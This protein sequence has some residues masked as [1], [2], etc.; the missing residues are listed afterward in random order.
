MELSLSPFGEGP[1]LPQLKLSFDQGR[2]QLGAGAEVLTASPFFTNPPVVTWGHLSPSAVPHLANPLM[3]LS[4]FFV[5]F[6]FTDDTERLH[7][8]WWGFRFVHSVWTN[9][10]YGTSEGCHAV[11]KWRRPANANRTPNRYTF[12]LF[13]HPFPLRLLG[14]SWDKPG[15]LAQVQRPGWQVSLPAF[16]FNFTVEQLLADN[17]GMT[18]IGMTYINVLQNGGQTCRDA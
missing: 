10:L 6:G 14:E 15:G 7:K 2:V 1:K 5:D 8:S 9:C 13:A 11:V 18:P 4:L 17:P 12:L 16:Q 3:I